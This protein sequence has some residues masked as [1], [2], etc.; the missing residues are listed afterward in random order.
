MWLEELAKRLGQAA[1]IVLSDF[2]GEDRVLYLTRKRYLDAFRAR[3][4]NYLDM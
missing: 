1:I 3:S 4:R 2:E